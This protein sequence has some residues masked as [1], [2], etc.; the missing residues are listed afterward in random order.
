M[1][2]AGGTLTVVTFQSQHLQS[3][4]LHGGTLTSETP[5]ASGVSFGTF[6]LDN[7][8]TAGGSTTTSIIS[9]LNLALTTTGGTTF[10]VN[11]GATNGIDLDVTGTIGA[12]TGVT[13]TG[14]IKAG[15]GVMRLSN[16]N[17]YGGGTTVSAGTL[18]VNGSILG[19]VVVNSGATLQGTGT[20]GGLVTVNS[21]GTFSPGNS[22]G[23]L[24]VGR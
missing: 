8:L 13:N 10:T 16:N 3:L 5:V 6:D 7:N 18:A 19:P 20:I 21:G 14:L 17:T 1:I 24:T 23:K 12:P 15:A 4:M 22:P 2:N 11:P 9:A